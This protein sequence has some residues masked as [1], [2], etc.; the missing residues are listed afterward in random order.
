MFDQKSIS[1][2]SDIFENHVCMILQLL[3]DLFTDYK[4]LTTEERYVL[5]LWNI[6]LAQP[7]TKSP[8]ILYK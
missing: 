3:C 2:A 4:G 7:C 5:K 6:Y 8:C 1:E